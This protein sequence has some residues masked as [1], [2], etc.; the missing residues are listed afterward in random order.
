MSLRQ[1]LIMS[2]GNYFIFFSRPISLG[3]MLVSISL[4]ALAAYAFVL[5]RADLAHQ[6][7]RR[8]KPAKRRLKRRYFAV[9]ACSAIAISARAAKYHIDADQKPDGPRRRAWQ[10]GKYHYGQPQI[11]DAADQH[12]APLTGQFS[13]VIKRE[14][15]R[16]SALDEEKSDQDQRQRECACQRRCQQDRADNDAEHRRQERPPETWRVPHPKCCD[17]AKD[18]TDQ[19][20]PAQQD[21][22]R[23]CSD[24]RQD[25]G[26]CAQ[27]QQHNAFDK[28]RTQCSCSAAVAAR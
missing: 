8:W 28:K 1:S 25:N 7:G 4:L 19:K 5:K 9:R 21:G 24:W 13:F 18:A 12:P 11:D 16:D 27:H 3:L 22:D 20:Q 26:G 2:N 17:Q 14:H 10:S 23:Q 15:D 6:A